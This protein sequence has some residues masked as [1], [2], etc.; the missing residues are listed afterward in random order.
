[1]AAD[2]A[3]PAQLAAA[4][5]LYT[6]TGVTDATTVTDAAASG[7]AAVSIGSSPTAGTAATAIAAMPLLANGCWPASC[8]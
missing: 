2:Y 3:V 7:Y 6:V 1:M 5:I 8:H 4:I